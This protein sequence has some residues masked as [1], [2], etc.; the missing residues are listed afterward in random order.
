M[1]SNYIYDKINDAYRNNHTLY[2]KTNLAHAQQI[3]SIMDKAVQDFNEQ[4][5]EDHQID[6][7]IN[8]IR[9]HH[10]NYMQHAFIDIDNQELFS[11]LT[12]NPPSVCLTSYEPDEDQLSNLEGDDHNLVISPAF[13]KHPNDKIFNPEQLYVSNVPC[14]HEFIYQ[15]FDRYNR[16]LTKSSKKPL[17]ISIYS[18]KNEG[19]FA[20]I[21]FSCWQD[22]SFALC[23]NKKITVLYKGKKMVISCRHSKN[24]E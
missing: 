16:G 8:H 5:S 21:T 11:M 18:S 12:S 1:N 17:Q 10:G 2:A 13:V 23:M 15:L 6:I 22:A 24:K 20:L 4:T 9:D 14:D 7:R 3:K 19:Y